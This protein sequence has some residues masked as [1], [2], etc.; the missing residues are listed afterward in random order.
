MRISPPQPAEWVLITGATHGIGLALAKECLRQGMGVAAVG[1]PDHHLDLAQK[2]LSAFPGANVRAIGL[3]LIQPGAIDR[4]FEWLQAESLTINYLVNNAGFGRG[5]LFENTDWTEYRNMLL[6]NNQVM[7]ELTYRLLPHLRACRGGILNISSMEATLPLPYK[8][9][10]TGTK[11]FVY[12]FSLA[13]REEFRYH[14][15][16][17][18]VLCP[19]PII[20]NEDGLRRLEAQGRRGRLLVALPEDIAPAAVNGMLTGKAVIVPGWLVR[21]IIATSYITPRPL[22]MRILE[23]LFSRYRDTPPAVGTPSKAR[24]LA[25]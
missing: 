6:L 12:N 8:T 5:G 22:R 20:T 1:L 24:N 13:L 23:K 11:A 9:V 21:A 19:G 15:V 16:S 2:E 17:V 4:L 18:S 7:V 14:G 3:D 25:N 10:Y